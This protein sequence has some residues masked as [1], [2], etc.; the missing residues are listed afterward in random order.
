M[1]K[2]IRKARKAALSTSGKHFG[3][4]RAKRKKRARRIKIY[5][6]I[7][8]LVLIAGAIAYAIFNASFFTIKSFVVQTSADT[9]HEKLI[10][11]LRLLLAETSAGAILG[12]NHYLAWP[13]LISDPPIEFDSIEV[14]KSLTKREI[15]IKAKPRTKYGLWCAEKPESNPEFV[16]ATCYWLDPS[17]I[18]FKEGPIAGGQLVPTIYEKSASQLAPSKIPIINAEEFSTIKNIL[19][20][21]KAIN[22][23]FEKIFLD[24][25]NQEIEVSLSN[26]TIV[27]FSLRIDPIKTA[28]PALAKLNS[29]DKLSQMN[30]IDL[31]VENRAFIK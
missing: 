20:G 5:L 21:I 7:T 12:T 25:A 17:G 27:Q 9:N 16:L 29:E 6:F 3:Q 30:Y 26:K 24:R 31:T 11:D 10:Q 1:R 14:E 19:T 23:S 18:I 15:T 22:L 8:A 28:L 13:K 4:T 2:K